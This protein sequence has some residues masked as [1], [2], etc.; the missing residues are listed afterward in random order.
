MLPPE[1]REIPLRYL[2]G[3]S[4]KLA[5][6]ASKAD[7]CE[8]CQPHPHVITAPARS[9]QAE[10]CSTGFHIVVDVQLLMGFAGAEIP[11]EPGN[12]E[13]VQV[14]YPSKMKREN[15]FRLRNKVCRLRGF[16]YS[17]SLQGD[18]S[19]SSPQG[20]V[21]KAISCSFGCRSGHELQLSYVYSAQGIVQIAGHTSWKEQGRNQENNFTKLKPSGKTND[22]CP[23][24]PKQI[25]L[26]PH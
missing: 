19:C 26:A 24:E 8:P 1:E 10:S 3:I 4:E 20:F 15:L 16:M 23:L 7:L 2:K 14:F 12:P 17:I 25:N 13:R 21:F 6:L 9:D 22:I 11:H 5:V 18:K